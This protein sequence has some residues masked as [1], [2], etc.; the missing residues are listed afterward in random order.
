MR[1]TRKMF[2]GERTEPL[3]FAAS[4]LNQRVV[5]G[6][7]RSRIEREA[8]NDSTPKKKQQPL[9]STG[10]SETSASLSRSYGNFILLRLH[11]QSHGGNRAATRVGYGQR[12]A[13]AHLAGRGDSS[14]AQHVREY[15]SHRGAVGIQSGGASPANLQ[16]PAIGGGAASL[17]RGEQGAH[18][19]GRAAGRE[20]QRRT[21]RERA[22][23][24]RRR[25]RDERG[26]R[27]LLRGR[28]NGSGR[29]QHAGTP[30]E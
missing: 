10:G 26:E 6:S 20:N 30:V 13:A 12:R 11:E 4:S 7:R 3:G 22:P 8:G 9:L 5:A 23:G 27:R 17:A 2:R 21:G 19:D 18:G 29:L 24:D 14:R 28:R 16:L 1:T 25:L 15:Q